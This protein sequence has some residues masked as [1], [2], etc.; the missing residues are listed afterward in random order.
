MNFTV[1]VPVHPL[2]DKLRKNSISQLVVARQLGITISSLS[3]YLNGY[4]TPPPEIEQQLN[5]IVNQLE[6]EQNV[7]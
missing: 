2:K 1:N 3:H 7:Q 5:E 4:R 6:V